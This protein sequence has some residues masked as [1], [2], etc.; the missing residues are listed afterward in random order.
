MQSLAAGNGG[1]CL[2]TDYVNNTTPLL[3][4][5]REGHRFSKP[6]ALIHGRTSWCPTCSPTRKPTIGEMRDLAAARG[7]KCLSGAYINIA[8]KLRWRCAE[9]HEW[10]AT[11]AS[12]RSQRSWCPV[13]AREARRKQEGWDPGFAR[14]GEYSH[15]GVF[16]RPENTHPG[17]FSF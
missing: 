1:R 15:H 9:G 17:E 12:V 3:W 8:T 6:F 16:P 14:Y 13:C 4:E 10:E 5:C 7:G 2:S 11:T